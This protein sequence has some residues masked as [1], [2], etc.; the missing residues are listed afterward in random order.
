MRRRGIYMRNGRRALA[1]PLLLFLF[2]IS[3]N[4]TEA[5]RDA[6]ESVSRVPPPQARL[7]ALVRRTNSVILNNSR[8]PLTYAYID[9]RNCPYEGEDAIYD[10][11]QWAGG[12]RPRRASYVKR[13]CLRPLSC[14]ASAEM[15]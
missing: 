9:E 2:R 7:R 13:Y 12:R 1:S 11:V 6:R 3:K 14:S 10:V 8:S 4:R 15:E 5:I